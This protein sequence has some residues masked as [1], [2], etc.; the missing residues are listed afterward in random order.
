MVPLTG[1]VALGKT[2]D[3]VALVVAVESRRSDSHRLQ[4]G[5]RRPPEE[6]SPGA[7]ELRPVRLEDDDV[8]LRHRRRRRTRR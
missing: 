8:L 5:R 4:S 6:L 2:S 1:D 7:R 3:G